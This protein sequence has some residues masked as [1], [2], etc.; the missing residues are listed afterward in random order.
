MISGRGISAFKIVLSL[1]PSDHQHA[2]SMLDSLNL[3]DVVV[4]AIVAVKRQP[5]EVEAVMGGDVK[6]VEHLHKCGELIA[7]ILFESAI[8]F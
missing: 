1:F 7:P 3:L 6:Y 2:A 4:L 8:T 5:K